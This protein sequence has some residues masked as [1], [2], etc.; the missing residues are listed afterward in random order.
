MT[1]T[2]VG[3]VAAVGLVALWLGLASHARADE[4]DIIAIDALSQD[5]RVM[6]GKT[7]HEV[8]DLIAEAQKLTATTTDVPGARRKVDRALV[9]LSAVEE[10]S[11]THRLHA[12][13]GRL[14]HRHRTGKAKPEDYTAVYGVLDEV[15]S[16]QGID[17]ATV[18]GALDRA[19]GK[20]GVEA[21]AEL[22]EADAAVGY[23]EMDLPVQQTRERLVAARFALSTRDMGNANGAL[24][25]AMTHTRTWTEMAEKSVAVEEVG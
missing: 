25:D 6:V 10:A 16:F 2:A 19:K 13:I 7:G 12:A 20:S 4:T 17:V 15:S 23:L 14:L 18:R 11:P 21:E 3:I 24:D 8:Y 22:A 1:R 9:V 5:V